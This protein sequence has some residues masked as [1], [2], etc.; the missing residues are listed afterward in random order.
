MASHPGDTGDWDLDQKR[1]RS[2]MERANTSISVVS[3]EVLRAMAD[4]DAFIA[5]VAATMPSKRFT[6]RRPPAGRNKV[7]PG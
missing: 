3:P 6:D 7:L 2:I 5:Q 4:E 1:R